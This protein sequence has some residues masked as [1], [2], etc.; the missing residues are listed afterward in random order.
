MLLH[1]NTMDE[2]A[3][4][5]LASD[6][7]TDTRTLEKF[8]RDDSEIVRGAVACNPETPVHCIENLKNDH[9]IHVKNCLE[10]RDLMI[11]TKG[12]RFQFSKYWH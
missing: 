7:K 11:K 2:H 5:R 10:I 6:N 1:R 3:K 9:S 4:F 8:S 12:K